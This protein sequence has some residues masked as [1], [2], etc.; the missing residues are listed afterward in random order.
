MVI[1]IWDGSSYVALAP[2]PF[3]SA[4]PQVDSISF[5]VPITTTRLRFNNVQGTNPNFREIQVLQLSNG[6]HNAS[7]LSIDTPSTFATGSNLFTATIRNA[8][9]N[10]IN[11]VNVN[12][13]VNGIAQVPV[14][15]TGL[16]DTLGGSGSNSQSIQ[17]GNF[18]FAN[19]TLYRVKV[20]TSLPNNNPDTVNIDDTATALFRSPLNGTFTVGA[21]GDFL[22]ITEAA[23]AANRIG[24]N[25]PVTFS[26]ISS[27]YNTSTGEVFPINFGAIPGISSTNTI[28]FKPAAGVTPLVEASTSNIFNFSGANFITFNGSNGSGNTRD[29]TIKNYSTS[30]VIYTLQNDARNNVLMNMNLLSANTATTSGTVSILGS[31]GITGNDNNLI[32]NNYFGRSAAGIF[33]VGIISTGQSNIIQNNN[34]N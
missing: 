23:I 16:L 33:A 10:Q 6:T 27:N 19:N 29:L 14:L 31:N 9:T 1:E 20:F 3:I 2:N 25:G 17:L 26:L 24:L 34:N 22:T 5:T 4:A 13:E 12:W 18:T 8:G 11:S 7:V 32:Q 28:T 30:G 21:T 15:Y